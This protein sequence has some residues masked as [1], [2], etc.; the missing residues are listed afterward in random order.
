MTCQV[1]AV[2]AGGVDPDQDLVVADRRTLHL[3]DAEHVGRAVLGLDDRPH[4]RARLSLAWLMHTRARVLG[5]GDGPAATTAPDGAV[6]VVA[7]RA[8]RCSASSLTQPSSAEP[9]VCCHG[10]PRKY[11]PGEAVT[12]R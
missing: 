11:R 5:H 7:I 6:A 12:P 10:R 8:A 9:R 3:R 2:Q 1:P 4:P